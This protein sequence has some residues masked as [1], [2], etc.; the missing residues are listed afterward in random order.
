MAINIGDGLATFDINGDAACVDLVGWVK[1]YTDVAQEYAEKP[2]QLLDAV[3]ARLREECGVKMNYTQ[4]DAFLHAI[5]LEYGEIKKNRPKSGCRR[6]LRHRRVPTFR[7]RTDCPVGPYAPVGS[8][9]DAAALSGS[10]N[11]AHG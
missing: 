8:E 1:W 4:A 5:M 2:Y 7:H 9:E 10:R 11:T 3:I 6:V